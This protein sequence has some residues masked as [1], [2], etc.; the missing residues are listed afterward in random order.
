MD[1]TAIKVDVMATITTA[2]TIS[3]ITKTVD[4]VEIVRTDEVVAMDTWGEMVTPLV[5]H[6]MATVVEIRC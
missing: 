3:I 4:L 1:V 2:V 5:H 6:I